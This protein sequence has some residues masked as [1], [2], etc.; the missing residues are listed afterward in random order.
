MGVSGVSALEVAVMISRTFRNRLVGTTVVITTWVAFKLCYGFHPPFSSERWHDP[1]TS[2]DDI[3][4]MIPDLMNNILRPKQTSVS[5]VVRLLG[6]PTERFEDALYYD[7]PQ[8]K[9][10]FDATYLIINFDDSDVVTGTLI[11]DH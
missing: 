7:L 9:A 1:A 10:A 2:D 8:R 11:V 4:A 3:H 6:P 5:D